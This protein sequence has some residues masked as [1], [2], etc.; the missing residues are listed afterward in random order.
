MSKGLA[1]FDFDGTI[2]R[3]DTFLEFIR[4]TKGPMAFAAGF[5]VLSPALV[6][7]KLKLIPNWRAKEMTLAYFFGGMDAGEFNARCDAFSDVCMDGLV[8]PAALRRMEWHKSEGHDIYI[9]S[10]SA[11]NWLRKWCLKQDVGLLATRLIVRDGRI[12]GKLSGANCHGEEKVSRIREHI[13]LGD[14][15]EIWA[16]GDSSGDKQ[17]L[18]L[19][20]N[21]SYK[22]FRS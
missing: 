2:T 4:Y 12:T 10:A 6:A 11:E 14:Y 3:R 13:P 8:R 16:Y 22:P 1:L 5:A 19:T 20:K 7:M 18:A 17:M 9:V 21:A 15:Q